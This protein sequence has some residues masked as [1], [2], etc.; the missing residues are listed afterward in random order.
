MGTAA[1]AAVEDFS[2]V[3]DITPAFEV[4]ALTTVTTMSRTPM[5]PQSAR[6]SPT[7]VA[8]VLLFCLRRNFVLDVAS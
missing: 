2:V 1:A 4:L 8:F 5:T 7:F 3:P 6:P